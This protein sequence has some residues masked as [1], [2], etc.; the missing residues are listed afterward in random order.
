MPFRS[1]SGEG[2]SESHAS[3][4]T[5]FEFGEVCLR[6]AATRWVCWLVKSSHKAGPSPGCTQGW[7][8]SLSSARHHQPHG[9]SKQ[10]C[11][12]QAGQGRDLR[13]SAPGAGWAG[14]GGS[15]SWPRS[16][17]RGMSSGSPL[18]QA[19]RP[20]SRLQLPPFRELLE[21]ETSA[22]TGSLVGLA[23]Q[24]QMLSTLSEEEWKRS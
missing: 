11:C 20:R 1:C 13:C 14:R 9:L 18:G 19:P 5:V 16:L 17:P 23:V 8:R 7:E 22:R 4:A 12:R 24:P 15:G 6:R 3:C 21:P 2:K 10:L